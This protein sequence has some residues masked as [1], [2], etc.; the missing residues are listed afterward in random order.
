MVNGPF[1]VHGQTKKGNYWLINEDNNVL[2]T[3]YQLSKLKVTDRSK[4]ITENEADIEEI[5]T[6]RR[7]GDHLEYLVKWTDYPEEE[8][9]WLRASQFNSTQIIEDYHNEPGKRAASDVTIDTTR[10][11]ATQATSATTAT[12]AASIPAQAERVPTRKDT[13]QMNAA[14]NAY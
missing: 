2:K 8:N 12:T 3:S 6:H 11:E 7:V 1:W 4:N 14:V 9:E 5:V 10:I 13:F